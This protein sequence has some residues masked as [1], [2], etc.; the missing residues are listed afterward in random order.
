[1]NL[2][3]TCFMSCIIQALLHIPMLRDYFLSDQ[4]HCRHMEIYKSGELN[5][6]LMCELAH[7]FQVFSLLL[8]FLFILITQTGIL[9]RKNSSLCSASNAAFSNVKATRYKIII[10]IYFLGLA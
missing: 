4:H 3:N 2:G 8:S 6:C 10:I 1:M 5:K 7:L 9:R